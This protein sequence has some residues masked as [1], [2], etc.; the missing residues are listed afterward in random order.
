[1]ARFF[2]LDAFPEFR[3]SVDAAR[4]EDAE[5]VEADSVSSFGAFEDGM[6]NKIQVSAL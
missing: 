6:L 3:T 4:D 1:V 2:A 5:S